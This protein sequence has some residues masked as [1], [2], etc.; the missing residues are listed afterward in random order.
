MFSTN[1]HILQMVWVKGDKDI[2]LFCNRAWLDTL[3]LTKEQVIGETDRDLFS[4][5]E[6]EKFIERDRAVRE[7]GEPMH[8]SGVDGS[9][10]YH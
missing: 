2:Y 7:S 10:E 6:A 8:F 5:Q 1:D 9:N 4:P 3:G